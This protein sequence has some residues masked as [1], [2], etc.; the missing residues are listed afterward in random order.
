MLPVCTRV[1]FWSRLCNNISFSQW[2][3]AFLEGASFSYSQRRHRPSVFSFFTPPLCAL[4]V[5]QWNPQRFLF[6]YAR[7]MISKENA[8][9]LSTGY[10]LKSL[11]SGK[12]HLH[13]YNDFLKCFSRRIRRFLVI[14][15]ILI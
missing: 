1:L 8:E 3:L 5:G 12:F 9:G 7:S 13:N 2:L 15:D 10:K 11:I 4:I 6:S 14:Y